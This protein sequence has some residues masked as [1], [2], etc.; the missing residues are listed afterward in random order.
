M[1]SG[2]IQQEFWDPECSLVIYVLKSYTYS[3][4][5]IPKDFYFCKS[6]TSLNYVARN[7]ALPQAKKLS[8]SVVSFFS[9]GLVFRTL[10][11]ASL[12]TRKEW[13]SKRKPS[14]CLITLHEYSSSLTLWNPLS[15]GNT[16][17]ALM[18]AFSLSLPQ[19]LFRWSNSNPTPQCWTVTVQ[20]HP[21]HPERSWLH[22]FH[23]KIVHQPQERAS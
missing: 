15:S 8:F 19:C 5:N 23:T 12:L 11:V 10:P 17:T 1:P 2:V 21:H 14:Y 6:I 3:G 22:N 20:P 13:F 9:K 16:P 18:E 7:Y 4:K